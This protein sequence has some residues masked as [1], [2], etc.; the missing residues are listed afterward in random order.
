MH[1]IKQQIREQITLFPQ[2]LEDYVSANNPVKI[3]D[4]F[5]GMLDL[6]KISRLLKRV[7]IYGLIAK[8]P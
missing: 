3:I 7:H 5:V 2:T 6:A 4:H 1:Y 8:I